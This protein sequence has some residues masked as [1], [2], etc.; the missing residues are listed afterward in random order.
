MALS[1][2]YQGSI[3]ARL[4]LQ[5]WERAFAALSFID[6]AI[7]LRHEQLLLMQWSLLQVS[8]H[9]F[10]FFGIIFFCYGTNS[11]SS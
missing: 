7:V 3:K 4:R 11:S 10:I 1:R 2:L 8:L 5:V 9:F 6:L